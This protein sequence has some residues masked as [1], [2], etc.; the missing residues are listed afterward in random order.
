MLKVFRYKAIDGKIFETEQACENHE[1]KLDKINQIMSPLRKCPDSGDFYDG[2]G[3]VRQDPETV[4][5]AMIELVDLFDISLRETKWSGFYDNPFVFRHSFIGRLIDDS[6]DRE[7]MSA[8]YRFMRMDDQY[9]EW[10]QQFFARNP[11]AGK[12]IEVGVQ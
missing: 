2:C 9:R 6:G 8:W 3:Y 5:R 12:Q 11:H 4:N 7:I 1:R 10:G